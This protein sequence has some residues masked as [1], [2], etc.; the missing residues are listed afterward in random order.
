MKRFLVFAMML[1]LLSAPAFAGKNSQNVN[2]PAAMKAGSTE[3]PPGDYNVTWTGS[4]S[5]VQ[6]TFISTKNRKA[7]ATIPAKLVTE[8]NKDERLETDSQGGTDV[9]QRIRMK[10]MTLQ[11]VDSAASSTK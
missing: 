10:N 7:V 4:G 3:L 5:E 2:I 8:T 9:L 11:F 6:V 1:T